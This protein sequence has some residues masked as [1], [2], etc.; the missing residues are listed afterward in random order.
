MSTC[1]KSN[2]NQVLF[3]LSK[4]KWL[5]LFVFTMHILYNKGIKHEAARVKGS[6]YA[7][8][9]MSHGQIRKTDVCPTASIS[10]YC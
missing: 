9:F 3:D 1:W 5:F 2:E 6:V 7:M 8:Q 4:V 10:L